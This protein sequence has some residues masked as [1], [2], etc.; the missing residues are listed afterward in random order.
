LPQ[1]GHSCESSKISS[2]HL[3]QIIDVP[4]HCNF[5]YITNP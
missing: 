2:P 5:I 4:P 3:L 1:D